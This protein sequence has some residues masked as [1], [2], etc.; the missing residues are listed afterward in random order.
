MSQ[1]SD[2]VSQKDRTRKVP[3]RDARL[4]YLKGVSILGVVLIHVSFPFSDVLRFCVPVFVAIW[5]YH[6]EFK[7]VRTETEQ[8]WRF[9]WEAFVRLLIP[10]V[11]WTLIY[12]FLFRTSA[13]WKATS[14]QTKL[15]GWLGGFGW[16]GQYYF[17]ILFQ[18]I[19]VMPVI[20]NWVT[21]KSVWAVLILTVLL[22]ALV[23]YLWAG[24]HVISGVG[25][26]CFVFWILYA[27]L[28][29]AFARSYPRKMPWLFSVAV[30]SC[31]AIPIEYHGLSARYENVPIYLLP[32]VTLGSTALLLA[33]SSRFMPIVANF[34]APEQWMLKL[35]SYIGRH[36]FLIFVGNVLIINCLTEL[37]SISTNSTGGEVLAKV[38]FAV[39]AI[40]GSLAIGTLLRR[41]GLGPLIG[42]RRL[43]KGPR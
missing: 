2:C 27:F 35:L 6:L 18:L 9:T 28:G 13:E 5:A 30:V 14:W 38:G 25:Y 40:I 31:L 19:W 33:A 42:E 26:R 37:V 39:A 8:V 22:D 11:F 23:C 41:L 36:T 7:L 3:L 12:L 29:I 4:D 16:P 34:G 1:L 24:N 32:S 15:N 20:R 17:L 43:S 10:F 21:P